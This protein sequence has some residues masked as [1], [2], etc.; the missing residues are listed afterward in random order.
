MRYLVYPL[1]L[2]FVSCTVETVVEQESFF[3]EPVFEANA[4]VTVDGTENYQQTVYLDTLQA[5]TYTKVFGESTDMLENQKYNGEA[6][7]RASFSTDKYWKYSGGVFEDYPVYYVY[8]FSVRFVEPSPRYDYQP[9]KLKL[10]TQQMVGPIPKLAI[11]NKETVKIY[12]EVS[13]DGLYKVK[14][15]ILLQLSPK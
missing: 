8:P 14:D 6:N 5:Y 3:Q 11:K 13:Y 10:Y 2:L 15:S 4:F 1:I 7:I 12:M 9:N